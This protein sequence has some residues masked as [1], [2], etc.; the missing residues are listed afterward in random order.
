M[1]NIYK[2]NI[3]IDDVNP[4][5]GWRIIGEPTEKYLEQ[6]NKDFGCKIT[7]FIPSNHHNDS[8]ISQNK[9]WIQELKSIPH[10]EL[11]A[12]GHFHDT[13]DRQKWGECEFSELTNELDV[14]T[15]I[16]LIIDEWSSCNTIP[17]VWKSPGWVASR[18][19]SE[20]LSKWFKYAVIH[21]IHNHNLMWKNKTI[22]VTD[23]SKGIPPQD[24]NIF[25]LSHIFGSHD[26]TWNDNFYNWTNK[27]VEMIT[28]NLKTEMCFIN[29]F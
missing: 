13:S 26:N 16:R 10:I 17:H 3:S 29:E 20:V 9:E 2:L 19:S 27:S 23:Y 21:P 5:K 22:N 15:R 1:E 8:R 28:K 25:I 18:A 4:K 7:L 6:L 24:A 11:A 14:Q 12:H